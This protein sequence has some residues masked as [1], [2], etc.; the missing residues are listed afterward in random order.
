MDR[1][2]KM[3]WLLGAC[4]AGA[5]FI[6]G[7]VGK[8]IWRQAPPIPERVVAESGAPLFTRDDIQDGQQV[9]Q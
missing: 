8:E 6:L 4:V 5:F 2:K 9:W 3:W 1:T 7:F